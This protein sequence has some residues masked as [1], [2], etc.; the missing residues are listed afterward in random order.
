MKEQA[1]L[2]LL[3]RVTHVSS[4][5]PHFAGLAGTLHTS[6]AANRSGPSSD[7]SAGRQPLSPPFL[8]LRGCNHKPLG[9][10]ETRQR[11]EV[12]AQPIQ[13]EEASPKSCLHDLQKHQSF[14]LEGCHTSSKHS[15]CQHATYARPG[16]NHAAGLLRSAG[17]GFD[18]DRKV[19]TDG[20]KAIRQ[21]LEE[22]KPCRT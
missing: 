12:S 17:S 13:W 15:L 18:E 2:I 4:C 16:R 14:G 11:A 6:A 5:S 22:P 20:G 7:D 8:L 21:A 19:K 3:R 1:H 9:D 10:A